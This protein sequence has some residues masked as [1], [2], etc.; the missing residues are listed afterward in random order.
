MRSLPVA[1]GILLC[2]PLL[3]AADEP[4]AKSD[5]RELSRL[6]QQAAVKQL[7]KEIEKRAGWGDTIPVPPNLP[8][9]RLRTYVRVGDRLEVP[10]GS[11]RRIKG[12]FEDPQKDLQVF[13]NDFRPIDA[14]T[15]RLALDVDAIITGDGEWQQWQKGLLLITVNGEADAA[16]RIS[17]VCDV[18]VSLNLKA[19]PPEVNVEPK[20]KE[21]H[22]D[23]KS[24]SLR[25]LGNRFVQAGKNK[26]METRLEE[27]LREVLRQSEPFLVSYANEAIARGLRE[28]K[29]RIAPAELFRATKS[30]SPK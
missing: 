6:L 17:L 19:L 2:G 13:V 11:W 7:P 28:G 8:L 30:A 29:G 5:Y 4:A 20:V 15:Y 18:G 12:R 26:E 14:S 1:A 3:S 23:L 9:P 21:M 25:Q 10:H 24:L 16:L 27:L 22:V